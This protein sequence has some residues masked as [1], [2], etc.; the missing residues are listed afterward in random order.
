MEDGEKKEELVKNDKNNFKYQNDFPD[1]NR[2]NQSTID[3]DDPSANNDNFL[4][5]SRSWPTLHWVGQCNTV[6]FHPPH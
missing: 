6:K 2:L 4:K 5:S 3:D 1:S